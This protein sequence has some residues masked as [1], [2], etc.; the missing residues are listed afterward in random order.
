MTMRNVVLMVGLVLIA[1]LVAGCGAPDRSVEA[2]HLEATLRTVAGVESAN[3]SYVNGFDSGYT[4]STD[5]KM[6]RADDRQVV[7]MVRRMN[8]EMGSDFDDYRTPVSIDLGGGVRIESQ[9]RFTPEGV[10]KDLSMARV[11]QGQVKAGHVTVSR[12]QDAARV[13]IVD[14][15]DQVRAASVMAASIGRVPGQID[16]IPAQVGAQLR[17]TVHT[18]VSA[19]ELRALDARLRSMANPVAAVTV[20]NGVITELWVDAGTENTADA[21]LAAIIRSIGADRSHPVRLHWQ[22]TP[23][24]AGWERD[25]DGS[26]TVGACDYPK[27]AYHRDPRTDFESAAMD[28]EQRIRARYDTCSR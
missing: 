25:A 24:V 4:V 9:T 22:V 19:A 2:E 27:N 11:A 13:E 1:A 20:D 23:V 16:V 12:S 28:L 14:A 10:A 3:V 17:W 21:T 5:V 6:P 15:E 18:P 7:A 26:A 8:A